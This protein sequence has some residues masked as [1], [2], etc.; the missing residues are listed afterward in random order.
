V[1]NFCCYLLCARWYNA[2][3][4]GSDAAASGLVASE[5]DDR[6]EII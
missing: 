2:G 4:Q 5:V 1:L 3:A 6:K